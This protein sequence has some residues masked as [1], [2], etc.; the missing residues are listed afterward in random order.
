MLADTTGIAS[1]HLWGADLCFLLAVIFAALAAALT[2]VP[3]RRTAGEAAREYVWAPVLG[4]VGVALL[5]LGW[6][7]L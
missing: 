4:W 7:L 1:G 2:V 3:V 5:A 6:L